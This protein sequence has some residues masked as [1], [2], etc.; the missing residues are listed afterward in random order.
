MFAVKYYRN[1]QA[2]KRWRDHGVEDKPAGWVRGRSQFMKHSDAQRE[3]DHLSS[4]G[5]A[6]EVIP[7]GSTSH[8]GIK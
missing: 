8:G 2:A 7:L 4:C 1:E 5:I 6:A 3:C